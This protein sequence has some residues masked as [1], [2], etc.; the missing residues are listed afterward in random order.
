MSVAGNAQSR[1][2]TQGGDQLGLKEGWEDLTR[3]RPPS[4]EGL[5]GLTKAPTGTDV[6]RQAQRKGPVQEPSASRVSPPGN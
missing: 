1:V 6:E 5:R 3:V 2:E 4:G